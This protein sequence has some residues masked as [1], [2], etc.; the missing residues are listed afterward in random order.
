LFTRNAPGIEF[1]VDTGFG[2]HLD[3]VAI[4][5]CVFAHLPVFSELRR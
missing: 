4:L 1:E 5:L 3:A 2:T